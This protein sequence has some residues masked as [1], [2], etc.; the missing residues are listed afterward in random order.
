MS[1]ETWRLR[2]QI[3]STLFFSRARGV[4]CGPRPP[5]ACGSG[6]ARAARS[7]PS[8]CNMPLSVHREQVGQVQLFLFVAVCFC[9]SKTLRAAQTRDHGLTT[10]TCVSSTSRKRGN[11]YALAHLLLHSSGYVHC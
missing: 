9:Q 7:A 5:R 10:R 6:G 2:V 8:R 3:T 11:Q 4:R 1:C